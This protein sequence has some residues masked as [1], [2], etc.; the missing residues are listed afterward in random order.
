MS[1]ASLLLLKYCHNFKISTKNAIGYLYMSI[2]NA[3]IQELNLK[4]KQTQRI[5]EVSLSTI[6]EKD[7]I[8]EQEYNVNL[9]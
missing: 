6:R 4:K 5:S 8:A 3:I 7:L 2:E 9:M 1:N